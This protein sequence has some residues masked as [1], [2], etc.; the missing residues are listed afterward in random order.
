M[1]RRPKT[2]VILGVVYLLVLAAGVLLLYLLVPS[3]VW[4]MIRQTYFSGDPG[5][6]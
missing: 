4:K 3:D 6:L 2:W 5:G 1:L